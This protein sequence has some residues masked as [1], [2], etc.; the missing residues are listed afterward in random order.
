ME[1]YYSFENEYNLDNMYFSKKNNIKLSEIYS[2]VKILKNC[3]EKNEFK[4]LDGNKF[5]IQ[6]R[7]FLEQYFFF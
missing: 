1:D 4:M 5:S 7:K 2:K 3:E 6:L